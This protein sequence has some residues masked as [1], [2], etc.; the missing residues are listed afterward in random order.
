MAL[1]N[2]V[3]CALQV[4]RRADNHDLDCMASWWPRLRYLRALR[5]HAGLAEAL[6]RHLFKRGSLSSVAC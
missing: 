4:R 1:F 5:V 2:E 3:G 6:W